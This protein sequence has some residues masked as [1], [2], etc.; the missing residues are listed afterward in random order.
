MAKRIELSAQALVLRRIESLIRTQ[1][2]EGTPVS[3]RSCYFSE[4]PRSESLAYIFFSFPNGQGIP[5]QLTHK[6]GIPRASLV[7]EKALPIAQWIVRQIRVIRPE[8][9]IEQS[10]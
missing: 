3:L 7:P 1:L 5:G 8:W 10:A 2:S 6:P 4:T 9:F